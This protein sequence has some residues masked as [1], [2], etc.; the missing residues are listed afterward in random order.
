MLAV[1][2]K[3]KGTRGQLKSR[4]I[5]GTQVEPPITPGPPTLE[6]LGLTKKQS[7]LAQKLA[8]LPA[9]Q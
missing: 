5:G 8:N 2:P 7:A 9:K 6:D 4:V 3:A 1:M